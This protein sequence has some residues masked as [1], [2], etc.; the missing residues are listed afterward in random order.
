MEDTDHNS[1]PQQICTSFPIDIYELQA[2][3][4]T[5]AIVSIFCHNLSDAW[6]NS[7]IPSRLESC[8]ADYG[9]THVTP[10][11]SYTFPNISYFDKIMFGNVLKTDVKCSQM[12]ISKHIQRHRFFLS[13]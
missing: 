8:N 10:N 7:F 4:D 12:L 9:L 2:K 13:L 3:F 1:N 6:L 5:L 11:V